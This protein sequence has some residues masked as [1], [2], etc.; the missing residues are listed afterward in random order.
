MKL[1]A[2]PMQPIS[3]DQLPQ[4]EE[5]GYQLKWDGVRLL[6][7]VDN[8]DVKL[9]SRAMLLKN[10]TYPE[11]VAALAR[12]QGRYLLDGEAIV[13]DPVRRRPVF[14]LVLQRER[15]RSRGAVAQTSGRDPAAYVMFDVLH[16]GTHDLRQLSFAE[17]H[18]RLHRLFPEPG[19]RLMTTELYKD[20]P[21]L[22]KWVEENEWE[23]VVSKRLSSPYREGKKHRDWLKK[24]TA[25]LLDVDII[26]LTYRSGRVAS[27]VM[28]R[29]GAYFGR[30]SLGLTE[31]MKA[32]LL[33]FAENG[34]G[35]S[36]FAQLPSDLKGEKLLWLPRPLP[37]K[38]TG[39]EITDAGLLRHPKIVSFTH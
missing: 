4:G 25:I 23:G 39:L 7:V 15:L 3:D 6:A 10:D 17:R 24:K 31:E 37:C 11:L 36:P 20:G 34:Q 8:G 26:G 22:W 16:E 1:P 13:F 12:L 27:L 19:E 29:N 30:I 9:Y 18:E 21:S 2:E 35:S 14:Q 28:V 33:A 32:L 5:W 38:A